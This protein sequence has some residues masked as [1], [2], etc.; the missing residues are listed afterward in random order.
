MRVP[1][2]GRMIG[3]LSECTRLARVWLTL[4]RMVLRR[5]SG[6]TAALTAFAL[7]TTGTAAT[8]QYP[9]PVT[10]SLGSAPTV[11]S[12]VSAPEAP[13]TATPGQPSEL[14]GTHSQLKSNLTSSLVSSAASSADLRGAASGSWWTPVASLVVPGSGQLMAGKQRGFAYMVLEGYLLIQA[15]SAQRSGDRDRVAY[16]QVASDVARAAFGEDRPVGPWAYYESLEKYLES[17]TYNLNTD[18]GFQPETNVLTYNG[19]QWRLARETYWS[20]PDVAPDVGSAEY[21]RALEFYQRRAVRDE[22][23]WS[24]RDAQLQQD[25]YRQHIAS[26]NR[27]YQRAVNYAGVVAANHLL[28]MVDAFIAVRLNRFGGALAAGGGTEGASL[29]SSLRLI[30]RPDGQAVQP[31]TQHLTQYSTRY[32][33]VLSVPFGASASAR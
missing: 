30:E 31:S 25:V 8:A 21:Q 1:I 17:G 11:P 3:R 5:G 13:G 20:D 22:F 9:S 29:H 26:A 14:L 32:S 28:S 2:M 19:A 4:G 7:S 23:R 33:V 12:L 6:L 10:L 24:W 18:N 15:I 16:R 27:N